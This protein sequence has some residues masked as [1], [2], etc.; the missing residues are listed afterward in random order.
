[1]GYIRKA[2]P[3]VS[4]QNSGRYITLDPRN[5]DDLELSQTYSYQ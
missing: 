4:I 2:H 1:M 5:S 3:W